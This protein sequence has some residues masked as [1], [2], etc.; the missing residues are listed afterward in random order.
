M[1]QP[2]TPSA[3]M[4]IFQ[5][6]HPARGA[7]GLAGWCVRTRTGISIHAPRK[8]CDS[9]AALSAAALSDISIHAPRKGCDQ[10]SCFDVA[11]LQISIHAPRK[12]CD[13]R[14][15]DIPRRRDISIHAPRKGCD[16]ATA[17]RTIKPRN[18]NPRTPQGVRPPRAGWSA[19]P[20]YFNPRTPQGVR[21]SIL[22]V[23]SAT[24]CISIHAPRKGCDPPSSNIPADR[25]I[26]IH[27]PRK[28]CDLGGLPAGT[29]QWHFNP[30]TPQGV[31]RTSSAAVRRTAYF[32]PR[33]PQGV[34][35]GSRAGRGRGA[36]I[37][38]H[39]P[40]KGCDYD[41]RPRSRQHHPFQSTHPARGA[42]PVHR[43]ALGD[44]GISIHA[45][46]K[47]CDEALP[48]SQPERTEISIH[49]PRK[50]CDGARSQAGPVQVISIHAPRK[51]CD[52]GICRLGA[53]YSF[54]STH[55][56]RG[57]TDMEGER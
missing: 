2:H 55:P 57:A 11:A 12:G 7:T 9:A 22:D 38:I 21:L 56:A 4:P 19:R 32:N 26:S 31:R 36:E 52:A 25:G 13:G 24:G 23:S 15:G 41:N 44:G 3:S 46:R 14:R 35:R 17:A 18:F 54:Q 37:S 29:G 6:T 30:R 33:T 27:A 45:P 5:S 20:K 34:R 51:G 16:T 50:G 53:P 10:K 39:A 8:G 48:A 42:T 40:R 43:L 49:A 1:S 28:G 47:G